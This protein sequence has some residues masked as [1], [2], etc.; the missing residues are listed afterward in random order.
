MSLR[1]IRTP[2]ARTVTVADNGDVF[3][4]NGDAFSGDPIMVGD[5]AVGDVANRFGYRSSAD[6]PP[7][8]ITEA[9]WSELRGALAEDEC[10]FVRRVIDR[11]QT[12]VPA[13]NRIAERRMWK[14][15]GAR[16][17]QR[18]HSIRLAMRIG[19][20]NK[21]AE[22]WRRILRARDIHGAIVEVEEQFFAGDQDPF[23][24]VTM[25]ELWWEISRHPALNDE[26]LVGLWDE[27][28]E[29]K[30]ARRPQAG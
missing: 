16:N 22:V 6:I 5:F 2:C 4:W 7:E 25:V 8:V 30:Y 1:E 17:S 23:F 26:V 10:A 20:Y 18:L 24:P 12:F 19:A 14:I 11:Q 21:D 29:S 27:L 28:N 9:W 13:A 3:I 15:Y